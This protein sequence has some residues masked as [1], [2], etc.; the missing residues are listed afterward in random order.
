M[1]FKAYVWEG[2]GDYTHFL[3]MD[4]FDVQYYKVQISN[5]FVE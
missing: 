5:I 2:L 4:K 1:T 3:V